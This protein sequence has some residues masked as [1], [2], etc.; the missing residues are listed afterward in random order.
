LS[1]PVEEAERT[2][3]GS[4]RSPC[5]PATGCATTGC[6]ARPR[7]T[8]GHSDSPTERPRTWATNSP[9]RPT[10]PTVGSCGG[11]AS[12]M[13]VACRMGGARWA[14]LSV[15]CDDWSILG[16]RGR[17]RGGVSPRRA[18]GCCANGRGASTVGGSDTWQRYMV[19]YWMGNHTTPLAL[20]G[21]VMDQPA[22]GRAPGRPRAES[23][24]ARRAPWYGQ[25]VTSEPGWVFSP[26]GWTPPSGVLPAWS[27][28]PPDG[29]R[30]RP[31]VM[32]WW[33]GVWYELPLLDRYAHAW[34]WAHGG[35]EV[36]PPP[37]APPGDHTGVREPRDPALPGRHASA[38]RA[39]PQAE[40]RECSRL[41]PKRPLHAPGSRPGY[42]PGGAMA[43]V[44]RT[45]MVRATRSWSPWCKGRRR[46]GR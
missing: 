13:A 18:G 9:R 46:T 20:T 4:S 27:W 37:G 24:T 33:V 44:F 19:S 6:P 34:M 41:Q 28:V 40:L 16:R 2:P 39:I 43:L 32:P 45:T 36:R 23:R 14:G 15:G 7:R 10:G 30:P 3:G 17:R 11:R 21:G 12:I 5:C 26:G 42:R 29:A 8:A 1:H 38:A 31:D 22:G 25:R 35:W